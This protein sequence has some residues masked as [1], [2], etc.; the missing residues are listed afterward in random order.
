MFHINIHGE[1]GISVDK[2]RNG[3]KV[4]SP[5]KKGSTFYYG[6]LLYDI[7]TLMII[8]IIRKAN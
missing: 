8:P 1:K 7:T 3:I 4:N 6:T 2:C 5:G